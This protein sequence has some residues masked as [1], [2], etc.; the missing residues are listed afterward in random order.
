MPVVPADIPGTGVSC[1]PGTVLDASPGERARAAADALGDAELARWC[2]DLLTG[3]TAYGS[4]VE[5]DVGWL[6]GRVGQTWGSPAR[7]VGSG[8]DYWVRTWAARTLLYVWDDRCST[9][10][11]AGLSDPAWR[12]RE[13]CAKVAARWEVGEAA[14]VAAAL[15]EDETTRVRVAALR[16]LAVVGEHEHLEAIEHLEHLEQGK[17]RAL[18]A[19]D[20]ELSVRSAARR[21]Q[22]ALRRRLDLE[23]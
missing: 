20:G 10:L 16:V 2:G 4:A 9:D 8:H 12:V 15:L 22:V 23:T 13:M 1:V 21:A 3:R 6:A 11:V 5:P 18:V 19:G 14:D 17:D 7:L